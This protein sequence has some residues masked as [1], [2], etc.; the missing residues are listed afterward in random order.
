MQTDKK[1]TTTVNITKAELDGYLAT[2]V[3][4]LTAA[5]CHVRN[6]GPN[7]ER[8]GGL[9]GAVLEL[10]WNVMKP[11]LDQFLRTVITNLPQS[12]GIRIQND[13]TQPTDTAAVVTWSA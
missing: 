10:F 1:T 3:P 7:A 5:N 6:S 8:N 11:D 4:T 13:A 9:P 2:F 12:Y